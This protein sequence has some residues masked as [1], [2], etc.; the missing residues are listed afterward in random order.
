MMIS[1]AG[2]GNLHSHLYLVVEDPQYRNN[3][4]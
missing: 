1:L 4:I 3:A 2:S